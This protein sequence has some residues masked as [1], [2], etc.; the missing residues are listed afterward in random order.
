MIYNN[1]YI[2]KNKDILFSAIQPTGSITIGH[3]LGIFKLWNILQKKYNCLY[4]IANLHSLSTFNKN[5]NI[6]LNIL[7]LVSL[8]L[9]S[10]INYN[11]CIIFLQ[12]DIIE[13]LQLYWILNCYTYIGELNRMTQFKDKSK[14]KFNN[15]LSLLSYPVLMASDILLYDSKYVCVGYDQLQHLELVRNISKRFN[16]I[17]NCDFFIYPEIIISKNFSKIM[18]LININKKMSKSDLNKNNVIFL[19]DKIEVIKD[20]INNCV[21]DSDNPP[22]IVFDIKN[23]PGIS[24]LLNI[25]SGIKNVSISSL[26]EYFYKCNYKK[27]KEILSKELCSFIKL[28]QRKFLFYRNN[29]NLIKNILLNG[30][31]KI[32]YIAK[33]KIECI[34]NILKFTFN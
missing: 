8:I 20:K 32:K 33:R 5:Y 3:Y 17:Y 11:K 23:K 10:G 29:E 19:L 4:C 27:F 34:N 14:N 28:L 22:K 9:A 13:H 7:D 1:Y 6:N 2:K 30:K 12:S 18:S 21:T 16:K 31:K 24:N 25:L 15:N 26:E